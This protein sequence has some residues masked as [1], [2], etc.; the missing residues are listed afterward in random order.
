MSTQGVVVVTGGSGGIGKACARRF[1]P[2]HA[3]VLA[4]LD[5][6]GLTAAQNEIGN[7]DIT[8]CAVDITDAAGCRALARHAA[9][10]GPMRA[11]IHTAGLAPQV[12]DAERIMSVN[13]DGTINLLDAFDEH[14]TSGTVGVLVASMSGHREIARRLD[15]I[16]DATNPREALSLA[17]LGALTPGVAY[18]ISK[19]A[20]M[21]QAAKRARGW[22][23]QGGRLLSV[24]PGLISDTPMGQRA[25]QGY[26]GQ[27]AEWSAVG[28]TGSTAEVAAFIELLC[29]NDASFVSGCDIPLDGG[30]LAHVRHHLDHGDRGAWDAHQE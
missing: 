28:R 12:G 21:I 24:S 22:G 23:A 26:A 1:S 29:S 10:R 14:V 6:T 15:P 13:L 8:C 2:S 3:V 27:Y 30:M 4:D 16:L 19:R 7:D 11:L 25:Q 20:T 9:D 5:E 18:A 17:N